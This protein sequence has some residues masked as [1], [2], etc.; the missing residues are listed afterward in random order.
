MKPRQQEPVTHDDLFRSRLDNIINMAHELVALS[1]RIDWSYLDE[2]AS[3]FFSEE[4]RPALPTR[5]ITGLHLLRYMF[6]LSDEG[7]CECF[8]LN[9]KI[10]P[11]LKVAF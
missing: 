2:S 7:V 4:G 9:Y 6:N 5:L 8:C 1:E 10:K 3:S 11:C